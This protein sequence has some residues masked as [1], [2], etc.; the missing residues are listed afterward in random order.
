MLVD[1]TSLVCEGAAL[2]FGAEWLGRG[3]AGFA[4]GFGVRPLVV[5]L[6]VVAYGTSAPELAVS[7]SA[8][9]EGKS[10]LALGNVVG[11]NVANLGLIPG[12]TALISP[13]KVASSAGWRDTFGTSAGSSGPSAYLCSKCS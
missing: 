11:S 5:G 10:S 6:T 1:V 12:A 7:C 4:C 2:Y 3:A 13:P 9:L 8:A